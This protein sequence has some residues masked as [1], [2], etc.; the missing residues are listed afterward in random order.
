ME[1]RKSYDGPKEWGGEMA[2]KHQHLDC[3]LD[4]R[5]WMERDLDQ[6]ATGMSVTTTSAIVLSGVSSFQTS[7]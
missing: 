2:Y 5:T 3:P 1:V 7:V 6:A 4:L